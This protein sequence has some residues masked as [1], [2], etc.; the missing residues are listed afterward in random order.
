[1]NSGETWWKTPNERKLGEF[2]PCL[3]EAIEMLTKVYFCEV[4]DRRTAAQLMM[5]YWK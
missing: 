1:M 5:F 4:L 2:W 3:D